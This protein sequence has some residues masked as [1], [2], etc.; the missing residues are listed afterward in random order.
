MAKKRIRNQVAEVFLDS[1]YAIAL[2]APTDE[3]HARATELAAWIAAERIPLITT[4][5][6]M[7]EIGNALAK[8]RYRR[9]AVALLETIERDNRIVK[10]PLSEDLYTS[11]AA[12][13]KKYVDKKWGLTDCVSFVV[14]RE[15]G[16]QEA[17]S[18]DDDFRQ[19]GFRALLLAG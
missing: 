12:L 1:S 11:A 19:A 13:Y 2:A 18:A 10:V 15:R 5:A 14:M 16:L 4:R 9:A 8:K 6:V 7:L 3:H 17:L